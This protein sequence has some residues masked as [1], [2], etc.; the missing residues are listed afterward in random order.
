MISA[1]HGP[2]PDVEWFQALQQVAQAIGILNVGARPCPPDVPLAPLQ[3]LRGIQTA[4]GRR[5]PW[6]SFSG[7]R[8]CY[9][10]TGFPPS[11]L[12]QHDHEVVANALPYSVLQEGAHI[13]V[14]G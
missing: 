5:S 7:C 11:A 2:E 14:H 12:A 9:R 8:D 4:R 13:A 10:G 3:P 6:S 1:R